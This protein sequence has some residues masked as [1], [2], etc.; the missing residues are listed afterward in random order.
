[1]FRKLGFNRVQKV[2]LLKVVGHPCSVEAIH[3]HGPVI[4]CDYKSKRDRVSPCDRG[5]LNF[6]CSCIV[7]VRISVCDFSFPLFSLSFTITAALMRGL[8]DLLQGQQINIQVSAR[9]VVRFQVNI[10]VMI[11]SVRKLQWS[12]RGLGWS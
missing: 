12:K 1:M 5:V 11:N 8:Y 3:Q 6:R 4:S 7:C 9:Q 10:L 2:K